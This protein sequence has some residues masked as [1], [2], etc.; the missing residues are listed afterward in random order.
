ML[1]TYQLDIAN[2]EDWDDAK[3]LIFTRDRL[4]KM[5]AKRAPFDTMW[6][7]QQ[8]QYSAISFY[9]NDWNLQP[10][11]P[12]EKSLVEIYMWR[13]DGKISYDIQP[14]WQADIEELQPSKYAL[15][16]FL[17][18]NQ[19]DNFWKENRQMRFNKAHYGSGIFYTW[20]RSYK[21]YTH[22]VKED[23]QFECESD[24]MN[25]KNFEKIE[26]ETWF[27][28]PKSVHP[29]DFF[30][31]DAAYGNPDVQLADDCIYK[32]RMT[33]MEFNERYGKN[34]AFINIDQVQYWQDI[35]PRNKD[36][37]PVDVRQVVIYHY[38]HRITGKYIIL[39]NEQ[40][41]IYNGLFLYDDGKLPFVNVQHYPR[42]DRFRGEWYNE[43]VSYLKGY[44]S[45]ILADILSGAAMNSG[46][47]LITGNDDQ[48]GQDWE[49]GWRWVNIW[50]TTA[51]AERV[52]AINTTVNLWYF[53][54][55]MQLLD[56]QVVKDS[57]VNPNAQFE[58]WA[59][60]LGQQEIMEA[61][62]SVRNKSVDEAYNIGLDEALTMTLSRIK[63]F[64]PALLSEKIKDSK[65]NVIKIKFPKIRI[66]N[67][68][69]KKEDGKMVFV[70]DIGKYW[71]FELKPSVVQW[72]GVKV[73]TPSTTSALPILE[74]QK[75]KEYI[76][77]MLNLANTAAMTQNIPLQQKIAELMN[78][79]QIMWWINDAF[80]Y[81][82]NAL[83]ANTEKDKIKAENL[84][85]IKAIKDLLLNQ[86]TNVW[87]NQA[88]WP[89]PP[90][91]MNSTPSPI[92]SWGAALWV[93]NQQTEGW[94]PVSPEASTILWAGVWKAG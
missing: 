3:R 18:W 36:D 86:T 73:V 49:V 35:N 25:E 12:L 20:I 60:T 40:T 43:R 44:Q 27:F 39:A 89:V 9:D 68:T 32:E 69:I 72:V 21:Y 85:K 58:A 16:F 5:R 87:P 71:Y 30:I 77:T 75:I 59:D 19:K 84:K 81:D 26:N 90:N 94:A 8:E 63:Q 28:F 34:K 54:A 57:W 11:I 80:Q 66:D 76:D 88:N 42:N 15:Q 62:K 50:R 51:W 65:G 2:S 29:K 83:K 91:Q 37:R 47:H 46:I 78:P 52:Q 93:P 33:A 41:I 67:A 23:A 13:T 24:V 55:V 31:D 4:Y 53:T 22:K 61:N 7:N 14:D 79:E 56:Q 6:D 64:A 1:A 10:N 48:I 38:F 17:D 45:E 74:R 82:S 92:Q 70:E